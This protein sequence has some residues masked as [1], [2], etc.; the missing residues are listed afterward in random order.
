MNNKSIASLNNFRTIFAFL[1]FFGHFAGVFTKINNPIFENSFLMVDF[2]FVLSGFIISYKYHS[3]HSIETIKLF[4]VKRIKRIYPLLLFCNLLILLVM[5]IGEHFFYSFKNHHSNPIEYIY[6]FLDSA[7]WLN[8]MPYKLASIPS[9]NPQSWSVSMEMVLYVFFIIVYLVHSIRKYYILIF[10]ICFLFFILLIFNYNYNNFSR[11]FLGFTSG[12]LI[13]LTRVSKV[14]RIIG[15]GKWLLYFSFVFTIGLLLFSDVIG[16]LINYKIIFSI[17][18]FS[19]F[20]REYLY[21]QIQFIIPIKKFSEISYS[22]YLNQAIVIILFRVLFIKPNLLGFPLNILNGSIS[23]VIALVVLYY[24][25]LFTHRYIESYFYNTD[26]ST[27]EITNLFK[28][29]EQYKTF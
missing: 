24:Y 13:D 16:L 18:F 5:I 8:I 21:H 22:V 14:K 23:L 7:F 4:F 17:T 27:L 3:M 10:G 29:N 1:V 2:F 12:I 28:K 26:T 9:L 25:S 19:I 20:L 15:K 11:A 6:A